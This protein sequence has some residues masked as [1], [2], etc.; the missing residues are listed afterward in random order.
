MVGDNYL[1]QASSNVI[2][3]PYSKPWIGGVVQEH[4]PEIGRICDQ[5]TL[6]FVDV[7]PKLGEVVLDRTPILSGCY[8][9]GGPFYSHFGHILVDTIVRLYAFDDS[10]FDGVIFPVVKKK[11]NKEKVPS[12]FYQIL[13]AY[14]IKRDKV[15]FIE[16]ETIVEKIIFVEPSTYVKQGVKSWFLPKQ[17]SIECYFLQQNAQFMDH[18]PKKLFLGRSHI[19][20][21]GFVAGESYLR[22]WAEKHGFEYVAPEEYSLNEQVAL[23]RFAEEIIWVEGSSIYTVDFIASELKARL[24]M[25]PR[26]GGGAVIFERILSRFKEPKILPPKDVMRLENRAGQSK[27]NSVSI[28]RTLKSMPYEFSSF[29]GASHE[30]FDIEDFLKSEK[31]DLKTY[32]TNPSTAI[33]SYGI[34][35]AK[36]KICRDKEIDQGFF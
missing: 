20:D 32:Y 25:I 30:E 2:V 7:P 35:L 1:T 34:A 23:L 11:W 8:L 26:R 4:L 27:P 21:K 9:Y 31:E 29:M 6:G 3:I 14:G 13:A 16:T 28:F 10:V 12:Y 5:K 24:L 19:Y 33:E 15:F 17:R 22:M 18:L 36:L